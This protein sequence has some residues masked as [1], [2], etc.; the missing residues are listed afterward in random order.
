MEFENQNQESQFHIGKDEYRAI[1]V[2][3]RVEV[4]QAQGNLID[5]LNEWV[6]D[7]SPVN[8]KSKVAFFRLLATMINAGVSLVKSLH[9]LRDQT[10]DPKL[11]KIC[12]SLARGVEMGQSLSVGMEAYPDVFAD[13]QVGMIRSG[14]ASGKLNEVLLQIA[15][16]T[17][18]GAK[19]A[20]KIKGAMMYPVA[21]VLV[22]V[23]VTSAVIILV[24]PK[25]EDMFGK[26]GAE[27]PGATKALI[28]ASNFLTGSVVGGLPNWVLC[29]VGFVAFLIGLS[30][31]KKTEKGKYLWDTFMLALPIFGGLNRKVALSRFCNSLATLTRSGIAI[32]KAIKITADI[33][34]NEVYKKRIMLI[35]DDVQRGI[36]IAENIKDDKKMFPV[37]LVSMI[38]VGEQTAQLD[39]VSEKVAD[40]YDEEVDNVVKNL[41]SL[42]EPLVILLIGG[43][44]GFLV[45]AIM[46]PIMKMS[47]VA[48]K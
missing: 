21:I 36:T 17:E 9:I 11:K 7:M 47:E 31:W 10:E 24:I 34:G 3:K 2:D 41:S 46:G 18:K 6:I 42:M 1:D 8:T 29:I 30:A 48:S 37:M 22:L 35:A 16:Q 40:F 20:G 15:D 33:V 32:V 12:A 39:N 25:L 28:A 27:L 13:A 19:I 38:G 45:A 14:E 43:V 26:A 4:E 44:V 23:V 5:R